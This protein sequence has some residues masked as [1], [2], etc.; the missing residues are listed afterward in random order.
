MAASF[1]TVAVLP[2]L[3]FSFK[4][5]QVS[6]RRNF[7]SVFGNFFYSNFAQIAL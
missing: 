1:N 3:T 7:K 2:V 5:R 4:I 6:F